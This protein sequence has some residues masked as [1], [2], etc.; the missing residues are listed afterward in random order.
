VPHI[1]DTF[2]R[3]ICNSRRNKLSIRLL[4]CL[5]SKTSRCANTETTENGCQFESLFR[6]LD[7]SL[8]WCY[9]AAHKQ[10]CIDVQLV[11]LHVL[12]LSNKQSKLLLCMCLCTY[13][14][15]HVRT[16]VCKDVR[17]YVRVYVR[18]FISTRCVYYICV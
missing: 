8:S 7:A 11:T 1:D 17:K 4:Q 15:M 18:V 6:F 14:C 16:Y 2:E 13:L 5:H 10:T 9:I 12:S 3:T